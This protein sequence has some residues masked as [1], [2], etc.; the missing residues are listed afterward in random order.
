[1]YRTA[2]HACDRLDLDS[3]RDVYVPLYADVNRIA[4]RCIT[5]S[6]SIDRT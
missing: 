1:V 6:T 5:S 2:L 4:H 3:D